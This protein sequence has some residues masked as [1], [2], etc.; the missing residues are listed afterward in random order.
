[1]SLVVDVSRA[2]RTPQELSEL[3]EAVVVNASDNDESDWIEW[4]KGLD[5]HGKTFRERSPVM[6][7]GWR[8]AIRSM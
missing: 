7:L 1:M 5:L 4:K 3:V 6:S 8:I 2:L